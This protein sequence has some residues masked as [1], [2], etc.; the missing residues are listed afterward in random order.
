MSHVGRERV[1]DGDAVLLDKMGYK[2]VMEWIG[3]IEELTKKSRKQDS[4]VLKLGQQA[5]CLYY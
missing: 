3:R 1:M 5:G 4:V 2:R